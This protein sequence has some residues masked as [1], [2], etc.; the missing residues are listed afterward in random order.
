VVIVKPLASHFFA[1]DW[2]GTVWVPCPAGTAPLSGG[3]EVTVTSSTKPSITSSRPAGNG[4]TVTAAWPA[5]AT[6]A[7]WWLSVS[8]ICIGINA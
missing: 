4:W 8:V 1:P 6:P 7:E 3:G 2:T 5:T